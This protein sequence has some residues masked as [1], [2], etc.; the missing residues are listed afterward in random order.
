[1]RK[2]LFVWQNLDHGGGEIALLNLIWQLKDH[3]DIS[4]LC[5]NNINKHN[6][7]AN[8]NI[9]LGN[10]L[11]DNKFMFW[12]KWF[13][14]SRQYDLHIANEVPL[15]S[16]MAFFISIFSFRKFFLWEHSCRDQMTKGGGFIAKLIYRHSLKRANKIICVSNYAA[17]SLRRYV[18]DRLSN[19]VIIPNILQFESIVHDPILPE[20]VVKICAIGRIAHE[21]NFTLLVNAFATIIPL[22]NSK[23]H[24]YICGRP[25]E[26]VALN[27]LIN[28]KNVQQYITLTGHINNVLSYLDQCDIFV[29]SS[30]SESWSIA[31]CEALYCHKPIIATRTGAS[32]IL[33]DG[34][35]GMI[36]DINN[37]EQMSKALLMLIN[38]KSLREKYS[39]AS[40]NALSKFSIA[41]IEQQWYSL[42]GSL[43]D[44]C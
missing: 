42:I 11:N 31:V 36:V 17:N 32:E 13:K 26:A 22:V 43:D 6:F 30:N 18:G 12:Y 41:A 14:I 20:D 24:L 8:V 33:E 1:M 4:V 27:Q 2:I 35:Y 16:I 29:S 34:K 37:V 21:K 19:I 38:D 39:M 9:I 10:S 15:L 23:I 7:P 5:Y 40:Q 3:Y 25:D 44:K 28:N